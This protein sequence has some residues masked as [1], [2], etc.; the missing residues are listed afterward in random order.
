MLGV[1]LV[2]TALS[3]GFFTESFANDSSFNV[4]FDKKQYHPGESLVISGE[5]LDIGMPVIAVSVYDPSGK[6]LSANNL[7][8]SSENTFSKSISLV[9]PFYEKAGEYT[10]KLD[11][12]KFLRII[13]LLLLVKNPKQKF[14][15]KSVKEEEPKIL[16]LSTEKK[17]YADK[18]VI[19]INGLV[20]SL[21]SPT[22]LIG[23]HD[24][25][26]MPVGFYFVQSILTWN[27]LQVS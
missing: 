9:S 8:I 4:N 1:T 3:F 16:L 24:P 7:E 21:G 15:E 19:K 6:I 2:L 5:I 17:Q 27:S 12:V 11:Y 18:D 13:T 20:S 25:F 22:V 26:G 23:V 10:V 14:P